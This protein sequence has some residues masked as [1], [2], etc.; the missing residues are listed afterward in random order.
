MRHIAL[1]LTFVLTLGLIACGASPAAQADGARTR[2]VLLIQIDGL[3][4]PLLR[5]YLAQPGAQSDDRALHRWVGQRADARLG[6]NVLFGQAYAPL[7]ALDHLSAATLMTGLTPAAH[8]QRAPGQALAEG[9]RTLAERLPS[10]RKAVVI[11]DWPAQ[12][13]ERVEAADDGAR[14]KAA[15][16]AL[17]SARFVAV[18]FEAVAR[19]ATQRGSSAAQPALAQLDRLLALALPHLPDDLQVVLVG[20]SAVAQSPEKV[21]ARGAADFAQLL[22]LPAEQIHPG[23][24]VLRLDQLS[25]EQV[26]TL[27]EIPFTR[28]LLHRQG[29]ALMRWDADFSDVRPLIEQDAPDLPHLAQR[30][31][32]ALRPGE[33]LAVAQ[34]DQGYDFA[35][36]ERSGP[37]GF[38][39]GPSATESAVP[40]LLIGPDLWRAAEAPPATVDLQ[41]IAPQILSLLGGDLSGLSAPDLVQQLRGPAEAE[42]ASPEA[43]AGSPALQTWLHSVRGQTVEGLR[44]K[45]APALS[46]AGWLDAPE[47]LSDPAQ[48]RAVAQQLGAALWLDAAQL[49]APTPSIEALGGPA[50]VVVPF[51]PER[52][53][54][55]RA[56][57]QGLRAFEAGFF[58]L[59]RQQLAAAQGLPEPYESWRRFFDRWAHGLD[60]ADED[61]K[62]QPAPED[63]WVARLE[64]LLG[65]HGDLPLAQWP[66]ALAEPS[67]TQLSLER[68]LS[69]S[70]EADE[71]QTFCHAQDRGALESVQ[72]AHDGL[73]RLGLHGLAAQ[74]LAQLSALE[75][76][77]QRVEAHTQNLLALLDRPDAHWATA[78]SLYTALSASVLR[79]GRASLHSR[80]TL[81]QMQRRY[82]LELQRQMIADTT[83]QAHARHT[84]RIDGLLIA[85][86]FPE[87]PLI[88]ELVLLAVGPD[89]ANAPQIISS[90]F[91][92]GVLSSALSGQLAVKMERA[93]LLM[94]LS[95]GK[96]LE[97]PLDQL[98]PALR[99]SRA[100]VQLTEAVRLVLQQQVH[101]LPAHLDQ[102]QQTLPHD[103]ALQAA[104]EADEQAPALLRYAPALPNLA[105]LGQVVLALQGDDRPQALRRSEQ[106]LKNIETWAVQSISDAPLRAILTPRLAHVRQAVAAVLP[107][108]FAEGDVTL[109]T[110]QRAQVA[111]HL[112]ALDLTLPEGFEQHLGAHL[113]VLVSI[114]AHDLGW[115]L[116]STPTEARADLLRAPTEAFDRLV[117]QWQPESNIAQLLLTGLQLGQHILPSAH[118][119]STEA[120]TDWLKKGAQA[121]LNQGVLSQLQTRVD[122]QWPPHERLQ[123]ILQEGN[124]AALFVNL[125]L[126]ALKVDLKKLLRAGD[127]Q[128]L[129]ALIDAEAEQLL[130]QLPEP[131]GQVPRPLLALL[132]AWINQETQRDMAAYLADQAALSTEGTP[133]HAG[134]WLLHAHTA[135]WRYLSNDPGGAQRALDAAQAACPGAMPYL[136]PLREHLEVR[137]DRAARLLDEAHTAAAQRDLGPATFHLALLTGEHGFYFNLLTDIGLGDLLFGGTRGNTQI[138]FGFKPAERPNVEISVSLKREGSPL[139]WLKTSLLIQAWD[140]LRANDAAAADR[141]LTRLVDAL[142]HQPNPGWFGQPEGPMGAQLLPPPGSLEDPIRLLWVASLAEAQG[143]TGAAGLLFAALASQPESVFEEAARSQNQPC[144]EAEYTRAKARFKDHPL[145]QYS[146]CAQPQLLASGLPKAQAQLLAQLAHVY[147]QKIDGLN[148][149]ADA[150]MPL[151]KSG[152]KQGLVPAWRLDQGPTQAKAPQPFADLAQ[153]LKPDAPAPTEPGEAQRLDRL[154]SG[155]LRC[156]ALHHLTVQRHITAPQI[157]DAARACSPGIARLA[158]LHHLSGRPDAL[159]HFVDA[160]LLMLSAHQMPTQ[161]FGPLLQQILQMTHQQP[162]EQSAPQLQRLIT[163]AEENRAQTPQLA[164][165]AFELRAALFA[166]QVR[167]GETITA[168]PEYARSLAHAA[169]GELGSPEARALIKSAAFRAGELQERAAKLHR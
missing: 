37:I 19:A 76:D 29:D 95:L 107:S 71:M 96:S 93:Y 15:A 69:V 64:A 106:L 27:T 77:P 139:Q 119:L 132:R 42:G 92:Q 148:P 165:V 75:D 160:A 43:L 117:E 48:I 104:A 166:A 161:Q 61:L 169:E 98:S 25:P 50:Q 152:V 158:S 2:R 10:D 123:A 101:Q 54:A 120:F 145:S 127:W 80:R 141:S 135:R 70:S 111:E 16:K 4:A 91:L 8:G 82:L 21:T 23:G 137:R 17:Q 6:R 126:A 108:F 154:L 116:R 52:L 110:A 1:F 31:L 136:A 105:L 35:L 14:A 57:T 32:E 44:L 151:L 68:V 146:F 28:L 51:S 128:P 155:P 5:A 63:P 18:R 49:T 83:P 112:R 150:L 164:H 87:D 30:A 162:V 40:V 22:H 58:P 109:T 140:D 125:G 133:L 143:H 114:L 124:V 11:G 156:Q 85:S 3:S 103:L 130:E 53:S 33:W 26:R 99:A 84:Q 36:P 45:G 115:Y 134:R 144:A 46:E 159:A 113:T 118:Q 167:A 86:P 38:I 79:G 100:T 55:L 121:H 81:Q 47:T 13:A 34:R 56:F 168:Q 9:V 147:A 142:I 20:G 89:L 90:L 78:S 24:G 73:L 138:G 72:R 12:G 94:R 129:L 88:A 102:L 65:R 97:Q 74:R 62:D 122:T 153:V 7:P 157:A 59:A 67:A 60:P 66:P 41:A 131:N 39:G 149:K 163:V